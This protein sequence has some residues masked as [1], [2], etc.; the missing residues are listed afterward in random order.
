[1]LRWGEAM[2]RAIHE[3][4]PVP[5]IVRW[6]AVLGCAWPL[7]F[8]GFLLVIYGGAIG[9]MFLFHRQ[10]KAQDD[11]DLDAHARRAMG[12]V[13]AILPLPDDPRYAGLQRV[14]HEFP[15]P[16]GANRYGPQRQPGSSFVAGRKLRVGDPVEIEYLQLHTEVSRVV[17]GHISLAPDLLDP[18][19]RYVLLPGVLCTL[20]WAWFVLRARRL[21]GNGDATVGDLLAVRPIPV[22][23]PDM[24]RVHYSFRDRTAHLRTGSH[25]VRAHGRL[26]RWLDRQKDS[27]HSLIVVHDRKD[28]RRSR[29]AVPEDFHGSRTHFDAMTEDSRR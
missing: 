22:C 18:H 1:M 13:V 5:R 26:M 14:E 6:R 17:G 3:L 28:A 12:K 23:I 21:L 24:V 10:G 2:T 19:L 16:F 27:S 20:A 4:P 15:V 9:L 8:L 25:W 11:R 7:L 29:L